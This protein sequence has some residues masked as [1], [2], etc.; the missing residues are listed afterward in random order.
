MDEEIEPFLKDHLDYLGHDCLPC[1]DVAFQRLINKAPPEFRNKGVD[2]RNKGVGLQNKGADLRSTGADL[3]NTKASSPRVVRV[4]CT[5]L[6]LLGAPPVLYGTA[7][8]CSRS[9]G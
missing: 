4:L 7:H 8:S 2:L 9:V 5:H 3:R 1:A 6:G